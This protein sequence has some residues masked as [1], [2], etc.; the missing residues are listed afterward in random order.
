MASLYG[1]YIKERLNHDICE[2]PHGFGTFS[3]EHE[4]CYIRDIFVEPDFR[5]TKEASKIADQ[6]TEIAKARGCKKLFGSVVP[7]AQG[8]T[9]SL[10]VLLAYGFKLHSSSDNFILF[11]KDI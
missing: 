9:T 8:S 1:R 7:S 6:I 2:S 4:G 3:F 5:Q 11:E 10:K